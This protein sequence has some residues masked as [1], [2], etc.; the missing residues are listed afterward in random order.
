MIFFKKKLFIYSYCKRL[1]D[2]TSLP[3]SLNRFSF[4]TCAQM[5]G[6]AHTLYM[7]LHI[8]DVQQSVLFIVC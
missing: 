1:A 2:P 3:N 4:C 8:I 5:K 6:V 7:N